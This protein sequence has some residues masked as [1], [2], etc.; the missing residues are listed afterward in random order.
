[1]PFPGGEP[2]RFY[3][4]RLEA[5]G[6]S[7]RAY[8]NGTFLLGATDTSHRSG[9]QGLITYKARAQFGDVEVWQP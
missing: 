2:N 4:L 3:D 7:I 8:V 5:V 6:T 1:M 9:R